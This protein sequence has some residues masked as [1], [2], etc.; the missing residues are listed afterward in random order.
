M[1]RR[2]LLALFGGAVLASW[3]L[4]ARGQY[5][6]RVPRIGVMVSANRRPV[7]HQALRDLGYIEGVNLRVETRPI[8]DADRIQSYVTELVS[9]KVDVLVVGGSQAVHAA[10]QAT[11]T[12]P[13]VMSSVSDPVG[14]GFV[15]SLARPGGNITGLSLLSPQLSGKRLE[16]LKEVVPR[17]IRVAVLFNPDDPPALLA[18]KETEVAARMLGINVSAVGV[19]QPGD[20]NTALAAAAADRAEA[21]VILSAPI[22]YTHAARIAQWAGDNQLPS[23][24]IAKEYPAAGGL[25]SYGP[26]IDDLVR[27]AA[28]YVDKILKGAKPADLPVEQPT[29]FELVINL[30]TAQLLGLT[31]PQSLLARADE[32][33]E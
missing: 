24:H 17:L 16:L 21:L 26:R 20:F 8:E 13:I 25:M 31:V 33:I 12:I 1:W 29:T 23:I 15:A 19:R 6:E 10:Q 30:K 4:T 14:T 32:V 28:V 5:T 11:R 18:L 27:R 9:L 7:L 22:M 3:P 2:E